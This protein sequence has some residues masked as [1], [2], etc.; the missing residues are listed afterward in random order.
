M[1]DHLLV[2]I[3]FPEEITVQKT[4]YFRRCSLVRLETGFVKI[5]RTTQA[6]SW[7]WSFLDST[8]RMSDVSWVYFFQNSVIVANMALRFD[9]LFVIIIFLIFP[10][11]LF[12]VLVLAIRLVIEADGCLD[13]EVFQQRFAIAVEVVIWLGFRPEQS[14]VKKNWNKYLEQCSRGLTILLPSG[15]LITDLQAKTWSMQCVAQSKQKSTDLTGCWKGWVL[16]SAMVLLGTA[17][18]E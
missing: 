16:P 1:W 18:R 7:L 12:L 13:W 5:L 10:V 14:V 2:V 17:G 4:I 11:V 15:L 6:V 9:T 8:D 3:H